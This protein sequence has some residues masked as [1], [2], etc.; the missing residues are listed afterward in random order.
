M[1]LFGV[2]KWIILGIL[3]NFLKNLVYCQK[4]VSKRI[5]NETKE[6]KEGFPSMLFGTLSASIA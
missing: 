4:G 5:K 6:Q 3:L 2:K 1:F